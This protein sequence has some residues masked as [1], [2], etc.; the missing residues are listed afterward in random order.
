MLDLHNVWEGKIFVG[1]HPEPAD[2]AQTDFSLLVLTAH[3]HQDVASYH[4]RAAIGFPLT[5]DAF[6]IVKGDEARAKKAAEVV[7]RAVVNGGKVLVTCSAGQNRSGWVAA[8][9]MVMLGTSGKEAV[10]HVQAR[11]PKSLYNWFFKT[12]LEGLE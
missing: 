10:E 9:A 8:W 2:L 3:Q 5:D 7:A 6:E 12:H 4:P 1:A 11:R